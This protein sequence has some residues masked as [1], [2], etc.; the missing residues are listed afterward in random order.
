MPCHAMG[1]RKS[2]SLHVYPNQT[3]SNCPEIS[4]KLSCLWTNLYDKYKLGPWQVGLINGEYVLFLMRERQQMT[5]PFT[6]QT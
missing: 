4:M 5:N 1:E 6:N 3:S 2:G